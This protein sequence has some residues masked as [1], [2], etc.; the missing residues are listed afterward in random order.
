MPTECGSAASIRARLLNYAKKTN[1]NYN[2]VLNRFFQERFLARLSKSK[3][4]KYFILKGGL[5]LL[6]EH[7]NKFRPTIDIDMLGVH[8]ENNIKTIEPVIKE[9][10]AKYIEVLKTIDG[11]KDIIMN[12]EF[13]KKQL[14]VIVDEQV[15][16]KYYI[17]VSQIAKSVRTAFRGSVSTSV[18][19]QK[20]E[21]EINV[22][23]RFREQERNQIKA[24]EKI[25]IANRFGKL[26]P[27][28]AVAKVVEEDGIYMI[29]H[30][31]GKRVIYVTANVDS[32][33]ITSLEV[34]KKVT[35]PLF[36][37]ER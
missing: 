3:Y 31:D 16:Q 1:E 24:F 20:A 29:N 34:N 35:F 8:I 6:A 2:A 32:D 5:L 11:V 25:L 4:Q 14:K 21:E 19:P 18:K 37:G 15:A 23:V 17:T 7:I 26:V 10:A 22:V 28:S 30:L 13:G 27:L 9:I 33:K 36:G 12:Y